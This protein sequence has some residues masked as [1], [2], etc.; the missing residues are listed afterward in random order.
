MNKLTFLLFSALLLNF[1][2]D[3]A[4][5]LQSSGT[6]QTLNSVYFT[7]SN[8]GYAV[9]NNGVILKTT[10]KGAAW[11]TMVS[12]TTSNLNSVRFIDEQHGFVVGDNVFLKTNNGGATWVLNTTSLNYSV[13]SVFFVNQN[14][15]FAAGGNGT[16]SK[17][18][19]GG[20][21]W[22]AF[23]AEP[24]AMFTSLYFTNLSTGFVVGL[25]GKYLKTTDG[26]NSWFTKYADASK[27]YYT[28]QFVDENTGYIVGGWVNSTV[29]K[30]VNS[31]DNW[32]NLFSN[33]FGVRLYSGSFINA[34]N[35]YVCGR[36][37]TILRTSD[38]GSSWI[39]ETS[40]TSA[41]LYGIHYLN[42]QTAYAVGDGG[43]ILSTVS[44]I[45]IHQISSNIPSEFSLSQN[46]PN[47]FNPTTKIKFSIPLVGVA[48]M[49]PVQMIVYDALGRKVTELVNHE[50]SPGTY[51]VDFDAGNLSSGT[52]FYRL[53]AGDFI[54]TMKMIIVK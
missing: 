8:T 41:F 51:E 10:D 53:E 26:G 31:G 15:G 27:N 49:R 6:T 16:I 47:P 17:T 22:S 23:L 50:L 45:G 42:D 43:T 54:K 38:G 7:S 12:G 14:T 20:T 19:N 32:I 4:W 30:S 35:G 46:Y 39:N 5:Y 29:M 1:N 2:T 13:K 21:S 11:N 33:A 37:G 34:E 18:T 52:Y 9:G 36:Y 48:Y 3:S 25:T 44:V 28:V 40:G 24:Y